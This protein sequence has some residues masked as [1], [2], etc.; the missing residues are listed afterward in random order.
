MARLSRLPDELLCMIGDCCD[1]ILDLHS[2]SATCRQ[3][4]HIYDPLLCKAAAKDYP[5]LL[6]WACDTSQLSLVKKLLAAGADPNRPCV[7]ISPREQANYSKR[8]SGLRIVPRPRDLLTI[9]YNHNVPPRM[10]AW[11]SMLGQTANVVA[12]DYEDN[13]YD[14]GRWDSDG[15]S[16]SSNSSNST[17]YEDEI[18]GVLYYRTQADVVSRPWFEAMPYD[19]NPESWSR[20][21]ER[22]FWFPLQ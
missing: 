9:V 16:N 19:K 21:A 4:H 15:S 2:L 18:D 3:F 20:I 13:H 7:A 17:R 14:D 8:V 12:N 11:R 6:T 1:H 22:H 10:E 5:H